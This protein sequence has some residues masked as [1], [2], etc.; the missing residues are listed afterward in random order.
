MKGRR[1]GSKSSEILARKMYIKSIGE[2]K[3]LPNG[4]YAYEIE[5]YYED[6]EE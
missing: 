3:K 6:E 1:I 4:D 2:A 5:Y